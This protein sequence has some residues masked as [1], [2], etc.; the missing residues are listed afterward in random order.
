VLHPSVAG[1]SRPGSRLV[2]EAPATDGCRT[3]RGPCQSPAE[4]RRPAIAQVPPP[5]GESGAPGAAPRR[6]FP[7]RARAQG[8][9]F[10]RDPRPAARWGMQRDVDLL[11]AQVA[12]ELKLDRERLRDAL[13]SDPQFSMLCQ[14]E[15]ELRALGP[16]GHAHG[17]LRLAFLMAE[18]ADRVA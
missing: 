15:R 14:Q 3:A 2:R 10:A 1:A 16:G 11:V 9:L 12:A 18:A 6:R 13:L 7:R 5:I 17:L 4:R 8:G